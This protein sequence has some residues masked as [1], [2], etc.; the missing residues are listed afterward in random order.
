MKYNKLEASGVLISEIGVGCMSLI[1]G[2]T[3][4]NKDIVRQA[5]ESGINYFDTADMYEKGLNETML[6][7][8]IQPFRQDV[9]L[10]SK[11]GNCW[12]ADGSGWEWKPSKAYILQEI[13]H[14]LSRLKTDYIDLYQLHGGTKED[15]M[16]EIIE[17]F[18]DLIQAGKIRSYGISS[19][20]PNVFLEYA[21]KSNI[22]TNM[23]QYSLLDRRP[24]TYLADLSSADV[25]VIARGSLAQGLLVD[26]AAK[27]YLGYTLQEVASVQEKVKSFAT[28]KGVSPQAIALSYVL[29]HREV[30]STVVGVSSMRQLTELLRAYNELLELRE[31]ELAHLTEGISAVAYQDHFLH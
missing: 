4:E 13:E 19:I 3:E 8:A 25:G 27:A 31:D 24:E 9:V 11:V 22:S 28:S 16:E 18:E 5:F 12:K 10:A 1:G 29:N 17:A 20:R 15:S 30:F 14:S 7:E 6:G 2:D 21:K 26:K 23:M